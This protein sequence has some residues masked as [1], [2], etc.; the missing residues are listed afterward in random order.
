[1]A[2]SL[3]MVRK[4]QAGDGRYQRTLATKAYAREMS[5]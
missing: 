3:R 2:C 1:M 4:A 5:E